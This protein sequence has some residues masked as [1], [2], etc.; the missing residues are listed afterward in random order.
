LFFD[1]KSNSCTFPENVTCDPRTLNGPIIADTSICPVKVDVKNIDGSYVMSLCYY[2]VELSYDDASMACRKHGMRLMR[3]ENSSE[4]TA[5]MAYSVEMFGDGTGGIYHV[6]GKNVG[7]E[8][9][10]DDNTTVYDNMKWNKEW[11]PSSGCLILNNEGP[12]AFDS[13]PCFQGMHSICEYNKVKS[14]A[15]RK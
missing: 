2:D 7:D 10:H 3:V 1:V 11:K 12:M 14:I 5:K 6:S 13:K 15:F 8:W 9:Y 4:Q